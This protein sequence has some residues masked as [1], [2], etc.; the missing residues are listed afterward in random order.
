MRSYNLKA[1]NT[2]L[3]RE[4]RKLQVDTLKILESNS[5]NIAYEIL[6]RNCDEKIKE[7]NRRIRIGEFDKYMKRGA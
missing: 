2:K 5:E 6:K 3:R 4:M 7:I 1:E